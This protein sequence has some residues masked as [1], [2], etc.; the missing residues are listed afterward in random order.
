VYPEILT[1]IPIIKRYNQTQE[2]NGQQDKPGG[3]KLKRA[4]QIE[5]KTTTIMDTIVKKLHAK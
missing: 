2:N 3:Y 4:K 5:R 1:I